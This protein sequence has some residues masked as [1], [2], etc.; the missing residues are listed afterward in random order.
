MQ[1]GFCVSASVSDCGVTCR[2]LYPCKA[3]LLPGWP[4]VSPRPASDEG[5]ECLSLYGVAGWDGGLASH[6]NNPTREDF[7][8]PF[9]CDFNGKSKRTDREA[10]NTCRDINGR[11]PSSCG[12][13]H[14]G[15]VWFLADFY[16]QTH[17][18]RVQLLYGLSTKLLSV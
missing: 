16:T 9:A 7:P 5:E 17:N 8:F 14:F 4:A 18:E 10:L 3:M 1:K 15:G 13:F 12:K 2:D 6:D 11:T